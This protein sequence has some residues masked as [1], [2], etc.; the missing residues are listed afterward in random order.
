LM[1]CQMPGMDGL[2]A[3]TR[4][5][6]LESGEDRVAIIAM[7]AHTTPEDQERCMEAGMDE[8]LPKPIR[9]DTIAEIFAKWLPAH[10]PK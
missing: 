10:C 1:D 4:I 6:S 3:T 7:T 5:R 8:F 9:P 2:E